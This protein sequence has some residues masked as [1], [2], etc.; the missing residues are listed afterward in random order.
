M[1]YKNFSILDG[2]QESISR[3][4]VSNMTLG[5]LDSVTK[6]LFSGFDDLVLRHALLSALAPRI[7]D[8]ELAVATWRLQ[9]PDVDTVPEWLSLAGDALH[10]AKR[11]IAGSVTW[12]ELEW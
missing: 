8:H 3:L 2:L 6:N 4:K 12:F 1:M 11:E 5:E 7:I 10:E 9:N